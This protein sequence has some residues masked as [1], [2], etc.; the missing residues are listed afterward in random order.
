MTTTE[1]KKPTL[2]GSQDLLA[3]FNLI[4]IYNRVVKPFPP[5]DRAAG[6]DHSLFPYISDLPGRTDVEHDGYLLNLLRDPQAV[7]TGPDIRPLDT[8]TLKDAFSL[9]EGPVPGV[10][11]FFF[12]T[13]LPFFLT[14]KIF[15]V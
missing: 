14:F 15:I 3:Y 2:T 9:K 8:E 13:Q 6:L 4:P 1:R 10:W 7:E 11:E 12:L 5:P